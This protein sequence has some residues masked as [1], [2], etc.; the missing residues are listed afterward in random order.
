MLLG[1][2]VSGFGDLSYASE[3]IIN[4]ADTAAAD[5]ATPSPPTTSPPSK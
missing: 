1:Y 4:E 2:S 5:L 3:K